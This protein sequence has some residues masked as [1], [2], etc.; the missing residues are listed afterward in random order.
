MAQNE[1]VNKVQKADGAVIMDISDSTVAPGNMLRGVKAYDASG[2]PITGDIG[3]A[4]QSSDGLMSA[5][6]KTKLDGID[7]GAEA[8]VQAN[9]T[10]A[11]A[12]SD[13]YIQNKPT[14]G[15]AAA[16][17]VDTSVSDGSASVNL[18]TSKAVANYVSDV[19][20]R[21]F[22]TTFGFSIAVTDWTGDGPYTYDL[23]NSAVG[24]NTTIDVYPDFEGCGDVFAKLTWRRTQNGTGPDFYWTPLSNGVRFIVHTMP[25]GTISGTVRVLG[26]SSDHRMVMVS[27]DVIPLAKG[28]TNA[29]N[30]EGARVNL[31]LG[32][33]E[34]K[35]SATIRS[36][37]TQQ[38]VND[39]LGTGDGTTRYYREDGTW[40]TPPDTICAVDNVLTSDSATNALSAAQGKKLNEEKAPIDSPDFTSSISM[41]RASG[42]TVGAKSVAVGNAVTASGVSSHA[43]GYNTTASAFCAHAEGSGSTASNVAAHAEGNG[44]TA[45]GMSAHAEGANTVASGNNSHAEGSGSSAGGLAAHAEGLGTAA[46]GNVSHAEGGYTIA[47]HLYQHVFGLYNAEDP[48]TASVT[49]QGTFIEIVGKG[50]GASARSNARTLDWSGN[51]RLAGTLYVN[52]N[53]DGTGGT[54]VLHRGVTWG[55]LLGT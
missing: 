14:L 35:S 45:G 34:N 10:E 6:D 9:W 25:T 38:N 16:K 49:Q 11:D 1:Y 24:A 53:A 23:T 52:A 2:E 8:N 31:G 21:P 29:T 7:T 46:N 44:S 51:E 41:G 55:D 43:E 40:A 27:D 30:A 32:A 17:G 54:Q 28:G 5:A 50:T 4:T 37:I 19:A 15:D 3:N 22:F 20:S 12:T 42:S 18:P 26:S 39:A 33:V 36:E 48:S 47:K 13:A